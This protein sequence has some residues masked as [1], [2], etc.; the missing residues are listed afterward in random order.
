MEDKPFAGEDALVLSSGGQDST[1]CLFWALAN[2][3]KVHSLSF[4]YGQKHAVELEAAERISKKLDVPFRKVDISFIK[5][6]VISNL[7]S[8]TGDVNE[9]HALSA[10]V[11]SSYVPYRN[12]LFLTVAS[13]WAGTLK[14]RNLVT[15]V[16]QTDSSG[17]ADCRDVFIKS[18]QA[19]LNLATDFTD[20]GI[21]IHTPLMWLSKA[22]EFRMA[23]KLGC[24]DFIL[25]ETVTC[26]NGVMDRHDFGRGCGQCP[27]CRL[28]KKGFDEYK[29]LI[30]PG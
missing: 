5:D 4:D 17:Y 12:L 11:P 10:N 16:C 26:Y 13:G 18:A 25:E 28:R 3:R 8:G 24:L 2:F 19:T 30:Q 23:E 20:G 14:I 15:G 21:R 9:P 7:F 6:I 27:S 22:E 29:A 1:T